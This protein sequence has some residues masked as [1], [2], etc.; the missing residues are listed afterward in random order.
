MNLSGVGQGEFHLG[1]KQKLRKGEIFRSCLEYADFLTK[2]NSIE[3]A[4]S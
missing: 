3:A 2:C 1:Q 4:I